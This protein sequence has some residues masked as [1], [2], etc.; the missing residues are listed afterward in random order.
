MV[1][2]LT[3]VHKDFGS[4]QAVRNI[5][6]AVAPGELMVLLGPSASGKTT[7]LRM[8]AG[9]E[10]VT[11]GRIEIGGRDVTHLL[12][13]HRDVAMVFQAYAL[14]PHM[15]VAGNIGYPLR[16][17]GIGR[18]ARDK[19]IRE[20]AARVRMEAHLERYP[21]TLSGG[22]KQRVAFARAIV[23]R[24]S[25]F[26]LDEPLSSLDPALRGDLRAELK[27]LQS[28][29]G[30]TTIYVTHDQIEAMTL[31]HRI[32]IINEGTIA[33]LGAPRAIYEDPVSRF[34]AGFMGSPAMN[35]INGALDGGVFVHPRGRV[36]T[37]SAVTRDGVV[38]GARPEG[39]RVVAP[40]E[41]DLAAEIFT[42]ELVGDYTL[43]T[44]N[45]DGERF[46]VKVPP[47]FEAAP[48]AR[49]GIALPRSHLLLFD[50]ESGAR[51]S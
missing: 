47:D 44:A 17:R 37:Q 24:P 11:S 27:R 48:G 25:V 21:G 32:A 29:L 42:T 1:V 9:L 10:E 39:C 15:T 50:A 34:V 38:L 6:L 40:G 30:V 23:R 28:D 8:I 3:A 33:Q 20:A 45:L 19:M 14:Y 26:L 2:T 36:L 49:I 41:G 13:K 7:I 16:L 18:T 5:T 31:A 4:L 46:Q 51:L 22:Q 43:V 35:L 12:P